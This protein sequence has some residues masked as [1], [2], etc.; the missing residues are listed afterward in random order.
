MSLFIMVEFNNEV[1]NKLYEKQLILKQN[2]SGEFEN[3]SAF[4]ITVEFLSEKLTQPNEAIKAMQ[5]LDQ[6]KHR[7]FEIVAKNFS[8]F[9]GGTYWIGVHNCLELYKIKH[10]VE[11]FLKQENF[12]LKPP[13]FKG[14]TPHITMGYDI[15]ELNNFDKT[16]DGIPILIDNVCLWHSYK[17]N[18]EY[19]QDCLYRVNLK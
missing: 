3:S 4:H 8:N 12:D 19:I 10:N 11:K 1:K 15:Q 16:F 6:M 7:K 9:D 2:C 17:V 5:L 18:D 14:Y 13:K